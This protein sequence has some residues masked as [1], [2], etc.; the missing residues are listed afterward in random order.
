[1]E[2]E[3][4]KE[5]NFLLESADKFPFLFLISLFPPPHSCLIKTLHKSRYR[6]H[7][8]DDLSARYG[9]RFVPKQPNN[10]WNVISPWKKEEENKFRVLAVVTENEPLN[11]W[12]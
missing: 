6:L 12:I 9:Q 7:R 3:K 5:T 2:Y 1:M 8:K 4:E 11:K 10:K